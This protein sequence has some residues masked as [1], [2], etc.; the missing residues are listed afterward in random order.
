ML[1]GV[2]CSSMQSRPE[3]GSEEGRDKESAGSFSCMTVTVMCYIDCYI[4]YSATAK[5]VSVCAI[6]ASSL[7]NDYLVYLNLF[8]MTF[9]WF[10][11]S[12][13]ES[14]LQHCAHLKALKLS[15]CI[16]IRFWPNNN[17]T[18]TLQQCVLLN[19]RDVSLSVIEWAGL[20]FSLWK[21]TSCKLTVRG[22]FLTLPKHLQLNLMNPLSCGFSFT[23]MI[24]TGTW[25][26]W[27]PPTAHPLAP[28]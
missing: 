2:R 18:V 24:Q 4:N 8:F 5:V 13:L 26:L 10:L 20:S 15:F 17:T 25:S 19:M 12:A 6:V 28:I 16:F 7:H 22:W 9:Y 21:L 23:E 14:V 1:A 27:G 3:A 11:T